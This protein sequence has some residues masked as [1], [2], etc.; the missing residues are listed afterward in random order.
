VPGNDAGAVGLRLAAAHRL[1][2]IFAT[3]GARACL[4]CIAATGAW[5]TRI[6]KAV[7]PTA[8]FPAGGT[9]ARNSRN[10]MPLDG[11]R[12]LTRNLKRGVM[13]ISPLSSSRMPS[14]VRV[15]P[16]LLRTHENMRSPIRLVE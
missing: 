8:E 14:S 6:G 12:Q 16:G 4:S 2:W 15:A 11:R 13:A 10:C 3:Y 1:P 9:A 5:I 7:A